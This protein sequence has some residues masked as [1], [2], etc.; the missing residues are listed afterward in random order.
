MMTAKRRVSRERELR[1]G[2]EAEHSQQKGRKEKTIAHETTN[3]ITI[4]A[5]VRL[6]LA[7]SA[8]ISAILDPDLTATAPVVEVPR[9]PIVHASKV[10]SD[11]G[12]AGPR[13]VV[14]DLGEE[15]GEGKAEISGE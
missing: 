11:L 12:Q 7:R 15:S 10:V 3:C 13:M 1:N 8:C 5:S 14:P 2:E 4:V 6:T 9:R